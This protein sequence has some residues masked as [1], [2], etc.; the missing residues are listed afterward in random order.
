YFPPGNYT[1]GSIRLKN[2]VTLWLESGAT[3]YASQDPGDFNIQSTWGDLV[4]IFAD[5]VHHI[6]IRGKGTIHGQARRTYENLKEVDNFISDVTENA[7][8]A[9]VEMK[10]YYK[11]EPAIRMMILERC[12]DITI[13]DVSLIESC[14][15]TMDLK[16]CERVFIRGVYI[17]SSLESGVNSDGID[18]DGCKNVTV[19][20][21][22][23]L[24]GDDAIALKSKNRE[25]VSY[26]C[27]NITVTNCVVSS[28]S[29]GLKIGTESYGDFRH[30]T[31][32]N[33]VV[34]NSNRGLSIVIRDGGTV[35][36]L[37]FSN[38]TIETNRKH[39]NW[40][41]DG[42]AIWLVI[43]KRRER[44][45]LGQIKNVVFENIIARS[46]GTSKLEGYLPDEKHP[47]GRKLENIQFRNVQFFMEAEDYADKRADHAFSAH[48]VDGLV[49]DNVSV[50][51]DSEKTEPKWANA[52]YLNHVNDL[53]ISDFRGRQGLLES[54]R[55]VIVMRNVK[56]AFINNIEAEVGTKKLIEILGKETENIRLRDLDI[57]EVA[58]EDVILREDVEPSQIIQMK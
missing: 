33:C 13:E 26:N 55:P 36:N 21:C 16:Q 15:W 6:A 32:S 1:S 47:E 37:I 44:S 3:L 7:R 8:Q 18:I 23:V 58:E 53:R 12:T 4:F 5:S 49:L 38:I 43:L 14:S 34:R 56:K 27:E 39:F 54:E 48:D 46:Q 28:T 9:G 51:W 31:F 42:D 17:Q 30:I 45:R 20:D 41:G 40:W 29:T 52:L 10:M 22:V 35:D 11:V 19:S 24:T 50:K 57:F 2:S 25:G